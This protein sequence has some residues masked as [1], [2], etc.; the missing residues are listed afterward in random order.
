MSTEMAYKEPKELFIE[1]LLKLQLGDA[2]VG[3]W[4][5]DNPEGGPQLAGSKRDWQVDYRSLLHYKGAVYMPKNMAV[6]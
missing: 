6:R 1:L 4:K 2:S 5:C 3:K